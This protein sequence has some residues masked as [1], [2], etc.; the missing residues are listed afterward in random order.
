MA[1]K[2]QDEMLKVYHKLWNWTRVSLPVSLLRIFVE[3]VFPII[4]GFYTAIKI[5][6]VN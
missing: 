5:L 2:S 4:F 3:F 1:G 6:N